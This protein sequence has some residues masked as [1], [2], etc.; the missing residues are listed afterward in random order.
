[1]N[2]LTQSRI[3]IHSWFLPERN[4]HKI[5]NRR[6]GHGMNTQTHSSPASA[7]EAQNR[8][9]I[10]PPAG[11]PEFF[12][13]PYPTYRWLREQG[14]LVSLRPN[15]L[16]CTRYDDCLAL[17]RDSRLSACRYMRPIA[18]YTEEQRGQLSTWVRVA[19]RQVIF[20][21]P[22]DHTRLRGLLMRA[23]SEAIKQLI[24]RIPNLFSEILDDVP[25]GV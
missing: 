7:S 9:V 22:P 19:S 4:D 1:M 21:D 11:S 5:R 20:M 13:D 12:R 25:V 15:V 17:L 10:V 3:A 8:T 6:I 16:A 14:P 23:F 24:P 18:H 2:G